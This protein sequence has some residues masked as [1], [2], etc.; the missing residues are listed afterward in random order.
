MKHTI[1]QVP[2]PTRFW[3]IYASV[4][5]W[6]GLDVFI[7]YR[8]FWRP[9][10][11][12]SFNHWKMHSTACYSCPPSSPCLDQTHVLQSGK[13]TPRRSC[14]PPPSASRICSPF[15]GDCK[16]API[17][18]PGKGSFGREIGREILSLF[19]EFEHF[20]M[21]SLY[22]N[23]I[24]TLVKKVSALAADGLSGHDN[25]YNLE[26]NL[27]FYMIPGIPGITSLKFPFP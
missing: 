27:A 9:G 24:F 17:P 12:S 1:S 18:Y 8:P 26:F 16:N 3:D 14:P 2:Q 15:S 22:I 4:H 7:S 25:K 11:T 19:A 13:S 23:I 6:L 10:L 5:S 21:C 20:L